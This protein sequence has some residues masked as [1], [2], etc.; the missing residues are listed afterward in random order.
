M[1][2]LG[3]RY[4]NKHLS[5]FNA[6]YFCFNS[7]IHFKSISKAFLSFRVKKYKTLKGFKRPVGKLQTTPYIIFT[8]Y[9]HDKTSHIVSTEVHNENNVGLCKARHVYTT[10]N[11]S[12]AV[13]FR[14]K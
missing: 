8:F 13:Q 11:M 1:K 14:R 7:S 5:V 2:N 9:F 3:F 12:S 4:E 6:N 10:V